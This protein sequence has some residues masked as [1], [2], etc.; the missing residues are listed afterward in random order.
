MIRQF[1]HLSVKYLDLEVAYDCLVVEGFTVEGLTRLLSHVAF[2]QRVSLVSR[3]CPRTARTPSPIG[4]DQ[5]AAQDCLN[6]LPAAV[7]FRDL[8]FDKV[9]LLL[10]FVQGHAQ[11]KTTVLR[12][13]RWLRMIS[14]WRPCASIVW[15]LYGNRAYESR[16]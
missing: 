12:R 14:S 2:I 8:Y 5:P 9:P 15:L 3:H 10:D 4:A 16:R 7:A 1:T 6:D 13:S 11:F